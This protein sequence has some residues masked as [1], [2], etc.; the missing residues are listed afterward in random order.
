MGTFASISLNESSRGLFKGAFSVLAR[1]DNSLSSYKTNSPIYKLNRDKQA[2]INLYTY[3]ALILSQKYYQKSAGYFNVAIGSVT[4]D[5]YRFG[6]DE[7]LPKSWELNTSD[8]SFDE[9]TFNKFSAKLGQGVKIDLGGF[10]KGYGVDRA[11]E[12]LKINGVR[13]ARVALSGDIRC[14]GVC[15]IN[16]NNPFADEPLLHFFT[17]NEEMAISTS[18]NYNRFVGTEKNNHL[19]NPKTKQSQNTFISI[20]LISTLPNSDIDAYATAASVMPKELAYEF[21]D[22]LDVAYVVLESDR[23]LV[24][25]ENISL[26]VKVEK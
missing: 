23:K 21:L 7:R 16:I 25:S 10:G 26:Y 17:T 20:T 19:I 24:V 5:L 8:T 22:S 4:K 15:E 6:K 11:I 3:E 1:V 12:Y 2:N 14:L 9:L 13:N 18:G